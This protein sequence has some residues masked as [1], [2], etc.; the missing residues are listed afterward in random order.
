MEQ[1]QLGRSN[2]YSSRII[3]GCM[4]LNDKRLSSEHID[5]D[6]LIKNVFNS[7]INHFDLADVYGSGECESMFS[8]TIENNSSFRE[9]IILTSK[10]G[11]VL[12]DSNQNHHVKYYDLSYD[13]IIKSV[14][15]SLIRL[16]T[17]YLDFLLLHRPDYI[18]NP[19][20]ISRTFDYLKKSGKVR[21]FGVSNFSVSQILMLERYLDKPLSVCQ[22]EINLENIESFTNGTLDL[23]IQ[24]KI[25][26]QAWSP[27]GGIKNSFKNKNLSEF[28]SKKIYKELHIQ[29]EKYQCDVAAIVLSWILKHPS[30]ILPVIGSTE[31]SRIKKCLSSLK[32]DYLKEDWYRIFEKRNGIEVP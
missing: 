32:L 18:L 6:S 7:G 24:Q 16:K 20:E 22:I 19:E 14:E 1:I 31:I 13:H 28:Q 25:S 12:K 26:P 11:V 29:S 9:K 4:R 10:C 30:K 8:K 5:S 23:C 2:V 17:D 15:G 27:L 21:H 3:Y